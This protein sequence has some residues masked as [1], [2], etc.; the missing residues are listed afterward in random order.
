MGKTEENVLGM[1]AMTK[2]LMGIAINMK[3]RFL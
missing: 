3:D 1:A 2:T